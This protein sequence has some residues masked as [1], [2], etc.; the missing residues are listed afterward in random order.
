MINAADTAAPLLEVNRLTVDIDVDGEIRHILNGVSFTLKAG[1][2]LG[3]VGES[4]SGKSM[5][6]KA[7]DRLLPRGARQGGSIRFRGRDIATF[8]G[9]EARRYCSEVAMVFQDPRVA[10]NPVRKIGDFMTEAIVTNGGVSRREANRRAVDMLARLRI[11]DGAR[12]LEQY[13]HELSGGLLQRVMIASTL[14]TEP[15]LLLADEPTTALDVSTQAEIMLI[16]NDLRRDLGLAVIFITHDLELAGAICDGL[17]VMYAGEIVEQGPHV[18]EAP[19]HPY[20]VEL[21]AAR[22]DIERRVKR[23]PVLT[24]NL[25]RHRALTA[26][27]PAAAGEEQRR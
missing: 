16:L 12:R 22:P 27:V 21:M 11:P 5:T 17:A 20:T 19:R 13:P 24:Y 8:K 7:I 3:L 1:E 15:K 10:I 4:G 23:L 9:S 18:Y 2:A 25:E 14:L 26:G 6:V